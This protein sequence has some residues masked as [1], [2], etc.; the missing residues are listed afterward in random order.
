MVTNIVHFIDQ[1]YGFDDLKTI[2]I[3]R[4]HRTKPYYNTKYVIEQMKYV[5]EF[6]RSD[7]ILSFL[8]PAEQETL[9]EQPFCL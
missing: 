5:P 6:A 1:A 8:P 9:K 4:Y 2:G 7:E 3:W